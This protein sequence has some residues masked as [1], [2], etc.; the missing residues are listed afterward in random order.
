MIYVGGGDQLQKTATKVKSLK[1]NKSQG[2]I[3]FPHIE[4]KEHISSSY[5][6]E[7]SVSSKNSDESP[8]LVKKLS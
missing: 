4:E 7:K 6:M 3:I 1:F 2:Q 5:C 8:L